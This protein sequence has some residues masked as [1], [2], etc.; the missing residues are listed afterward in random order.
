MNYVT[1]MIP[2]VSR[3]QLVIAVLGLLALVAAFVMWSGQRSA[4]V[5]LPLAEPLS[6]RP[7][8]DTS[9][10][11]Y[12]SGIQ[13]Q[14]E[15]DAGLHTYALNLTNGSVERVS[16]FPDDHS[17]SLVDERHALFVG[18]N[19]NVEDTGDPDY[20]LP[21]WVDFGDTMHGILAAVSGWN[22][23]DLVAH[24]NGRNIAY[25]QQ[26]E[27]VD[28]VATRA[29]ASWEVVT[30][31]PEDG[32]VE[33]IPGASA[34]QWV[35]EG[36]VYLKADGVYYRDLT[37]ST[38]VHLFAGYEGLTRN[39]DLAATP[40][41][42]YL[43]ITVPGLNLIEV[44][45][46]NTFAED[47]AVSIYV[48]TDPSAAYLHPVFDREHNVFAT[49]RFEDQT[50]VIEFRGVTDSQVLQEERLTGFTKAFFALNDWS[51]LRIMD[52]ASAQEAVPDTHTNDHE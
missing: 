1:L 34:P 16:D 52:A 4:D 7:M 5:V 8:V 27:Q 29:L 50:P 42:R 14:N 25:A 30:A 33:R 40:D 38:D 21:I 20:W 39:A 44:L 28:T 22:E 31:V 32:T 49:V 24:P 26:P 41:G 19:W 13:T 3:R 45:E 18:Q 47:G 15:A 2:V 23:V 11:L 12:F 46:V 17:F 36:L 9:T 37:T 51:P 35:G 48:H 6:D 43:V 10:Y